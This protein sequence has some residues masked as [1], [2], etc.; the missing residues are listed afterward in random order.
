M[1][2]SGAG[3]LA[4]YRLVTA[5]NARL[6]R[7][8]LT[9]VHVDA[10]PR[11]RAADCDLLADLLNEGTVAVAVVPAADPGPT[12]E[13][14]AARLTADTALRL[15]YDPTDGTQLWTLAGG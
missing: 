12:A 6:P 5:L 14:L 10:Y 1:P 7:F 15:G 13:A 9:T 8:R 3:T 2:P 11:L 4:P